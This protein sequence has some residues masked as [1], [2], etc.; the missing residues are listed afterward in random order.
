MNEHSRN[1]N[2]FLLG[3]G[4][5]TRFRPHT[6]KYP[7]PSIP[8]LNIPLAYYSLAFAEL[9]FKTHSVKSVVVNTFYLPAMIQKLF[10]GGKLPKEIAQHYTANQIPNFEIQFSNEEGWIRES[11]GG[12]ALAKNKFRN[13]SIVCMNLDEVILP[14]NSQQLQNMVQNHFEE[15]HFATLLT[16]NHPEAGH[17]FGAIWVDAEN[18]VKGIGKKAPE[19]GGS[20]KPLHYIGVQILNSEVMT[21]LG[22]GE[23]KKN[24]FYDGL[25]HAI[26]DGKKIK[27]HTIDCSW[28]EM[29]NE[30]D[31]LQGTFDC[32]DILANENHNAHVYLNHILKNYSSFSQDFIEKRVLKPKNALLNVSQIEEKAVIGLGV[33][34]KTNQTIKNS[35]MYSNSDELHVVNKLVL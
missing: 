16:M 25:I 7:K 2:F 34:F 19:D 11:G 5:G 26:A 14:H 6:L 33:T 20:L 29:G 8:F 4:E 9:W 28:F 30:L 23:Q 31:Y 10:N 21:Y 24:I 3:A 13:G 27:A 17:K 18:N 12:L 22:D 32:L 35:V 1:L 15:S